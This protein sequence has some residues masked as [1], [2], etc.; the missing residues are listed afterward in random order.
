MEIDLYIGYYLDK[1][2]IKGIN[3]RKRIGCCFVL[4]VQIKRR[5][6]AGEK[7]VRSIGNIRDPKFD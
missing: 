6:N 7:I 2:D 3:K 1:T 4:K 5:K